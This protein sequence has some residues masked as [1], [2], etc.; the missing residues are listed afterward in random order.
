M[1][2]GRAGVGVGGPAVRWASVFIILALFAADRFGG[3][4]LQ[5]FH[6]PFVGAY[7]F[8]VL[9]AIGL[10]LMEGCSANKILDVIALASVF[11]GIGLYGVEVPTFNKTMPFVSTPTNGQLLCLTL[12]CGSTFYAAAKL[13][14]PLLSDFGFLGRE[15]IHLAGQRVLPTGSKLFVRLFSV[16]I[17][18]YH[19][20]AAMFGAPEVMKFR[21]THVAMYVSLIFLLYSYKR[22]NQ[23]T[24]VPWFDWMLAIFAWV[25]AAYI[26]LNYFYVVDRYPYV[27]ELTI[28]AWLAGI[29]ALGTTIE[30]CRRAVGWTLTLLLGVFMLHSLFGNFFPGPLSQAAVEPKRLLDHLF[31]TTQGLYGSITGISATY[32][33]MFVLLGALLEKARGGELFMNL[34][35]GLMGRQPG[36]PGKAAV[37]ASGM[38]GS[39]SGAAVA[40]VYATGTFTIPLMI[41]TGFKRRFAAAVEAVASASGQLVPPIMGSAA[42]LIADFTRLPYVDV[43][44]SAALPA[45]LYLF[46]VYFM[47]HLETKKFNLPSMAPNLVQQARREIWSDLHMIL[48]LV[49]VVVLLLDRTTPFFA[50]FVGVCSILLFSVLSSKTQLNL[51]RLLDGFE[52]GAR[53]IAPIAGALFVAALVVG[54][55]ELSGLGLRFTSILINVTGGSLLFTLI[56]V[57]VSCILLGMGLPTSAAYMIVA[58]FGA[59]ALVKL[60]IEPLAAH[61]FVFY[62]AIISAITPPVAVAAY[63]AATIAGTPLQRTGIEAMKLGA[64]VY[65]VPFVM[66]YSPALLSIGS[67]VEIVQALI[68]GIIAVVSLGM[69]VQGFLITK[70]QVWERGAAAL[71]S[72]LLLH[73]AWETDALG[74]ILVIL[75]IISQRYKKRARRDQR[76]TAG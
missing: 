21:P 51:E 74:G 64:A 20:A 8:L 37:L 65:L 12:L 16:L 15:P 28:G 73:G 52:I 5:A 70:L 6:L 41:K 40:N 57:M 62:Y 68:T 36:G 1:I 53:R 29:I 4:E 46:A 47:V 27:S 24:F 49:V 17:I 19:L 42:F 39:I 76:K 23:G 66:V 54:T 22:S 58:I 25:P 59:P 32:V 43:A 31:M 55:I 18:T 3:A 7:L 26:Y 44:K 67:P 63:A 69:A 10:P 38:F 71:A 50:A 2:V 13:L 34:A 9:V 61:F 56:L 45:C 48:V 35:T 30:A 72:V 60:G 11:I 33:L 14:L 75:T